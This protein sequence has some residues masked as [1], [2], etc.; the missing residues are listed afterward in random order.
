MENLF[1]KKSLE[2]LNSPD[3]LDEYLKVTN[4]PGWLILIAC[5]LVLAGLIIWRFNVQIAGISAFVDIF[6]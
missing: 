2:S 6:K 1:R 5:M 4:V 3:N